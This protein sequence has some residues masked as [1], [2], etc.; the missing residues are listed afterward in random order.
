ML[1]GVKPR[2]V[3]CEDGAEYLDRFQRFLAGT[4]DFVPAPDYAAA[5]AAAASADGLLLDLDFRRTPPGRLVGDGGPAP[6]PLS[7]GERRRLAEAQ[8]IWILR[9]LRAQ[10]VALPALLFADFADAGQAPFLEAT[11][12]PLTVV[13]SRAGLREIA[14]LMQAAVRS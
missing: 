12:A 9:L 10:G 1:P 14:A 7:D 2:F 3:V 4:F 11:L 8:G 13:S 5:R 6:S